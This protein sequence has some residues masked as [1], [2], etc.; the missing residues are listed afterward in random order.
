MLKIENQLGSVDFNITLTPQGKMSYCVL[1][2]KL[3]F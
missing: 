3:W 1:V 2:W